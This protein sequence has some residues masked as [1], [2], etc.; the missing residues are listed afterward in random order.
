MANIKK[1]SESQDLQSFKAETSSIVDEVR[2]DPFMLTLT[3]RFKN[4]GYDYTYV[5]VPKKIFDD[6]KTAPSVGKY[7]A[8]NVKNVYQF[9]SNKPSKKSKQGARKT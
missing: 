6:L 9:I 7:F 4:S 8:A 1:I 3:V 2:Y 5:E